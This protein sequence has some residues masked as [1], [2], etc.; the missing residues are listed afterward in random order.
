MGNARHIAFSLTGPIGGASRAAQIEVTINTVQEGCQA[1]A[2]AVVEKGT[3]ARGP[4]PPHRMMKVMR[5]PLLHMILKSGCG[6]WKKMLP[7]MRQERA[8]QLITGLSKGMLILSILVKVVGGA[9][10]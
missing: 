8:M 1:I 4:G 10:G 2:E 9:E 3:K 5:T 6:V 7:K